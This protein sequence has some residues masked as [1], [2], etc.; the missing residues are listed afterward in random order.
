MYT[1]LF[2]L[3]MIEFRRHYLI[4]KP[5]FKYSLFCTT[6]KPTN[7]SFNSKEG[8]LLSDLFKISISTTLTSKVRRLIVHD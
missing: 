7:E 4:Y 8:F 6:Y 5:N 2:E 3:M 1:T